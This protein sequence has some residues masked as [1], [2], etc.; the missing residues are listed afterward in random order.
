MATALAMAWG[1]GG[2][3]EPAPVSDEVPAATSAEPAPSP[4]D[5]QMS[6]VEA[7][8]RLIRALEPRL[9]ALARGIENLRLPDPTTLSFY[10]PELATTDVVSGPSAAQGATSPDGLVTQRA[11]AIADP[12]PPGP[13]SSVALWRP[14]FDAV[15]W[16]DGAGF[17]VKAGHFDGPAHEHFDMKLALGAHVKLADGGVGSL[18]GT[19]HVLWSLVDPANPTVPTSWRITGWHTAALSLQEAAG[20]LFREVLDAAIPDP[21]QRRQARRSVHEEMVARRADLPNP[22]AYYSS[23]DQHPGVSVVDIDGDGDDDLYV[24]PRWGPNELYVNRGDGRFDERAA[25]WGL[26]VA[27]HSSSALFADFDNDGDPDLFLGRSLA[28]SLYLENVGGR[29][30]DRSDRVLGGARL[31]SLVVSVSAADHDGDGLLDVYLST[32]A[33]QAINSH[34]LLSRSVKGRAADRPPDPVLV[35]A[36]GEPEA[37]RVVAALDDPNAH[38]FLSLPGPPNVL[39]TNEGGGRFRVDER[40]APLALL[41]NTFQATWSD[42]DGDG[43]P[44]LYLAHDYAPNNLFRND[45]D[46]RFTDVTAETD[47]A[48]MGFGMGVSWG[49]FDRDGRPDLYVTNMYSKAGRRITGSLDR[50]D[51]RFGKSARGNSLLRNAPDGFQRLSS[52]EPGGF[53]AEAAGWGWGSQFVD[54]DNDGWLDLYAPNGF[55]TS[56]PELDIDVDT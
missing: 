21:D 6:E 4:S 27:D 7:E 25:A 3:E 32:Y 38:V 9:R 50:L 51:P 15:D 56:P 17:G 19:V 53:G 43:D 18:G 35:E 1:C 23:L 10:A 37:R 52:T 20:P 28:P 48:D 16:I 12:T 44:D 40:A 29:F 24:M 22:H 13:T 8:E 45:G 11:F 30:E 14:L 49:D 39:L 46:G 2:A 34:L 36:L 5:L 33:A 42:Y 54:I 31:P 55:F 26:D 41:R 47:T